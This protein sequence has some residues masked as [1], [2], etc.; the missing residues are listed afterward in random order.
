MPVTTTRRMPGSQERMG[1]TVGARPSGGGLVNIFDGIADGQ[2]RL[3]SI[4]WDL[5]AELLFE[6]HHELDRVQ[7]V[8]AKVVDE[9]C[10]FRDLVGLHAKML[11]NDFL[12]AFCGITHGETLVFS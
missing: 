11:D 7:T 2:D 4:V 10:R 5:D 1:G 8:G 12:D 9:A 6:G 3:R